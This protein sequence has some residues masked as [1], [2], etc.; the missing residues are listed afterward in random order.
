MTS[1]FNAWWMHPRRLHS[2]RGQAYTEYLVV[3]VALITYMFIGE[4]DAIDEVLH[5]VKNAYSRFT[6]AMSLP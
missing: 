1:P 3:L 5:A 6:I 2:Q 4:P